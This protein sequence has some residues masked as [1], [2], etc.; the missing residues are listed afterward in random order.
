MITFLGV[1]TQVV[2]CVGVID[3]CSFPIV[4]RGE[5]AR[6]RCVPRPRAQGEP[7]RTGGDRPSSRGAECPQTMVG[8]PGE[9]ASWPTIFADG[10]LAPSVT[11]FVVSKALSRS[12]DATKAHDMTLQGGASLNGGIFLTVAVV[13]KALNGSMAGER[14]S[15][16]FGREVRGR[17]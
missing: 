12:V 10:A 4:G 9:L 15:K 6:S 5:R 17:G 7:W 8:R 14:M 3:R 13:D 2:G 11:S 1:R 16:S